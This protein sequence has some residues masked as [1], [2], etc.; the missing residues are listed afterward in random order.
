MLCVGG[1]GGGGGSIFKKYSCLAPTP[2]HSD[3]IGLGYHLGIR[4]VK[5]PSQVILKCR[6]ARKGQGGNLGDLLGDMV[7]TQEQEEQD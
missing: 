4:I 7:T 3:F 2:S 6:I 1:L 5:V